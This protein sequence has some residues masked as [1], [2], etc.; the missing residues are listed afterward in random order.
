MGERADGRWA[1]HQV[2][3]SAPRQNGKSQI[4]VA[5]AIAGALLFGEKKIVISAHLQDT[6]R[7]TFGKF[8]EQIEGNEALE[9][10]L[11][12]GSVRTGVM[13]AL[14][15]EHIKFQ[16]G[17]IIKFKAR[18]G[19]GGR[20]FSSD[21][22]FL[23]E[24]Q[25]LG[26]RAWAS[27]NSTMSARPNPQV[28]LM[29]TPPT[30]EDDGE[31]FTKVR[32]SA[33]SKK[34][35]SLAW[36]EW[37]ADPKDDPAAEATRAK[38]NPAWHTRINHEVVEGEYATYS[39][40][41]FALERLGIWPDPEG[42]QPSAIDPFAWRDLA[43]PAPPTTEGTRSYGVVF[44]RDGTSVSLSAALKH[45]HGVHVETIARRPLTE[46]TYWL[47][48]FFTGERD[49]RQRHE[50]AAQIVDLRQA[51]VAA[52]CLII[53]TQDN[54]ITS[55]TMLRESVN[56]GEVTH[57]TDPEVLDASVAGSREHKSGQS[58]GWVFVPKTD[59]DDSTP[60]ESV[61]MALWAAKTSKR[62]PGR[63]TRGAVMA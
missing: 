52:K 53:G 28:W 30:P 45:R 5:R 48:E 2:G 11:F 16:N 54:A 33:I 9:S 62:R 38:A 26:A 14:N 4:I 29:G 19:S 6:A 24:A 39:K 17:A 8:L 40:E 46:G 56:R 44:H 27:I 37:A 57:L 41:Q 60:V 49:G 7:E 50:S 51:G 32:S 10:R 43:V 3:L 61:A 12:G 59:E 47:V 31:V 20:G 22:L 34:A 58:G 35:T 63:K 36:A 18:S 55:A 25:I 42:L 15:R 21:C 23:D 1:A 13:N